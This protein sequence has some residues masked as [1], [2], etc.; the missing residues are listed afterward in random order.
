MFVKKFVSSISA[1]HNNVKKIMTVLAVFIICGIRYWS[2][3]EDA[4]TK[5]I[6]I[7]MKSSV[8]GVAKIF[9]DIGQGFIESNSSEKIVYQNFEEFVEYRFPFPNNKKIYN[10]RFDPLTSGGHIKIRQIGIIDGFGNKFLEFNLNNLA[11]SGQISK[12]EIYKDHISIDMDKNADDPQVNIRLEKQL[13]IKQKVHPSFY[14]NLFLS[15]CF[16][17]LLVLFIYFWVNWNDKKDIKRWI[18][19]GLIATGFTI[20]IFYCF[21]TCMGILNRSIQP[22]G[23]GDTPVFVYMAGLKWTDPSFYYGPRPWTA[24]LLHSLFNGAANTQNLILLQTIVSYISWIILA[25]VTIYFLRDYLTKIFAFFLILF[26]PLNQSIEKV[27]FIIL[28]ESYS[29]SFLAVFI[30]SFI[31]YFNKRSVVS[32]IFLSIIALLFAF[33]RDTD[34]YRVLS[35]TLPVSALIIYH[36]WSKSQRVIHHIVLLIVFILIFVGSNYSTSNIHCDKRSELKDSI[37][38]SKNPLESSFFNVNECLE[39]Y[40]NA[41]WFMPTMNNLFQRIL[42]FEDR[43]KYFA[44][45]G[46]P[47]T[48][49]LM[50]MKYKWASSDNWQSALDPELAAQREWNYLYGR[51]TYMKYLITHPEYVVTSA[52]EYRDVLIYP[53]GIRNVLSKMAKPVEAKILSVFFINNDSDLKMFL[54]LFFCSIIL[55]G[56]YSKQKKNDVKVTMI[57]LIGYII[58]ITIP[59]GLLIFHGDIMDLER[60]MFTNIIQ[61][62]L[63]VLLFYLFMADM[64]MMKMR[65]DDIK[66]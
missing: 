36:I 41:R 57:L 35:M 23:G 16:I 42:P 12:F 33:T 14:S 34:A 56:F 53:Y 48:P 55:L 9:Y 46:L 2:L 39:P 44:D 22:M 32:V 19:Y 62:N 24:P 64:L 61:M 29:I 58:L 21:Q 31:W 5:Y 28:S 8:A 60:H 45:H 13:I 7:D 66:K 18:Y 30:A 43:V 54:D 17:L 15:F 65:M 50:E 27:N 20:V 52:L 25:F 26:I 4:H 49:A 3:Y 6:Q 47:V 11:P 59:L 38:W 63:G 40:T 1:K 10:L 51:Q 37:R